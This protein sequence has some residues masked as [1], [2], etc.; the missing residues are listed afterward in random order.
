MAQF[1]T[2]YEQHAERDG[3]TFSIVK[4]ITEADET[5]DKEVLPMFVI[6]FEDGTQ[7]EAWPEEVND[8]LYP[9]DNYPKRKLNVQIE[10]WADNDGYPVTVEVTGEPVEALS[11]RALTELAQEGIYSQVGSYS[12]TLRAVYL[13]GRDVN[14]ATFIAEDKAD[15]IRARLEARH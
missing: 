14:R 5:H 9:N 2:V 1:K 3:Q 4:A 6:E 11:K 10:I 7:I 12:S 15:E 8:A 13:Y